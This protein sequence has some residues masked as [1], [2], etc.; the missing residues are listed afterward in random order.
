ML[1]GGCKVASVSAHIARSK[2]NSN[3]LFGLTMAAMCVT[4]LHVITRLPEQTLQT[5]TE[6]LAA[7]II[8]RQGFS[9]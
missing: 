3:C 4:L 6:I 8:S 2:Y 5:R 7:V 1:E 9:E